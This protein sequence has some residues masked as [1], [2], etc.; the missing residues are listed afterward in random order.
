[1]DIHIPKRIF[2]RKVQRRIDRLEE[3]GLHNLWRPEY[4]FEMPKKS[5][6]REYIETF[7]ML[8]QNFEEILT[9]LMGSDENTD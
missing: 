7:D 4:E 2:L 3:I 9:D 5:E 8:I 1:M 6:R